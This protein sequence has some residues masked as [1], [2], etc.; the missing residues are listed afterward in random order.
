MVT[1]PHHNPALPHVANPGQAPTI[2]PPHTYTYTQL[3]SQKS[4]AYLLFFLQKDF[5]YDLQLLF[6]VCQVGLQLGGALLVSIDLMPDIGGWG[7]GN[8]GNRDRSRARPG[9]GGVRVP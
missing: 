3:S 1:V 7:T 5:L 9:G 6:G 4:D 2:T 8:R